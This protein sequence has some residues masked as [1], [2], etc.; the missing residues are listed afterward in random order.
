MTPIKTVAE[1]RARL[2]RSR[3]AYGR[4][5]RMVD[6]CKE[7]YYMRRE[8]KSGYLDTQVTGWRKKVAGEYYQVC[9][10]PHNVVD[11]M[12]A[13]L[14]GHQP[15]YQCVIPGNVESSVP[16]RAE[17]FLAGVWWLNSLR[18][19]EDLLRDVV[20]KTVR[21]GAC[22]IRIYWMPNP[23]PVEPQVVPDPDGG[24]P[25]VVQA[26]D[27]QSLPICIE[28]IDWDKL[29][30]GE[31]GQYGRPF[32]EIFYT[33]MR[34]AGSVIDE[35]QGQ[36]D[37]QKIINE[38]REEERDSRK[39]E[40]IEWWAQDAS[41]VVWY[42]IIFREQFII[43]PQPTPYPMIPFIITTYKKGEDDDVTY[44]R[45][46]F[47]YPLFDSVEKLEYVR[48]RSFR[49]LDMFAA[50]NP[51]H[52][53]ETPLQGV[54]NT[55][56]KIIE[57]G[58]KEEITFPKWPGQPPDIYREMET[59]EKDTEEG[60]FSS[61]MF[62]QVSTRVSGYALSQVIG[63]DT[64]RTDIPRVNL[65]LAFAA[66][67]RLIFSLLQTF[68]PSVYLAV[69]AEIKHRKLAAMLS[70][71][72]TRGLM[73]QV[74]IKPKQTSD[75]I[76][77]ASLGAQMSSMPNPPV[78]MRYILEHYFGVN[79][80]EEELSRKLDED[81]LKEPITRMIAMIE[82]LTEQGSPYAA[83]MQAQ[84]QQA[85]GQS[86]RPQLQPSPQPQT[87]AGMGMGMP[88]GTMGNPPIVGPTGNPSAET[89]P[90]NMEMMMGGPMEE[91]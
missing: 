26:H 54:D 52:A 15:Q 5:D 64:L 58:P 47:L 84:L 12:T 23:V 90:T 18:Q 19:Q 14:S 21:D 65:E 31:P 53:G 33:Q 60:S 61:V 7:M 91:L 83:L 88:Q 77:L 6:L 43:T 39:E 62:G 49:Q 38:T 34:T 16:S 59:L 17:V 22:G 4:R 75:E 51:V 42:A 74:Y 66:S 3:Q 28:T 37:L 1:M 72:E 36:A 32:S 48:S 76:R 55:W 57:L 11:I 44:Q 10:K 20:F 70:G 29:Y 41:G 80:P 89:A 79:Q 56:G 2:N 69:T 86:M 78:S 67:A 13:V 87:A 25:W 35:W 82:V 50:M 45:L 27:E 24:Q 46:P 40:Y 68:A 9:N 85:I 73:T 8:R 81:A 30:L 63:A 71:A